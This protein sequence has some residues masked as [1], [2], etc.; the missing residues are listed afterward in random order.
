MIGHN[1]AYVSLINSVVPE[2]WHYSF[3]KLMAVK[4]QSIIYNITSGQKVYLTCTYP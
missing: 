4:N 3:K 1:Q 2:P